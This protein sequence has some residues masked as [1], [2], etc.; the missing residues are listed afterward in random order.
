MMIASAPST[1]A[2][3]SSARWPDENVRRGGGGRCLPVAGRGARGVAGPPRRH[4]RARR[5]GSDGGGVARPMGGCRVGP[6]R[7]A[8]GAHGGDRVG[9]RPA[10]A[11]PHARVL[12]QRDLDQLAHIGRQVGGQRGGRLL[13]VLHRHRQRAVAG[14]RPL[15]RNHFVAND[16]QRVDVAGGGRVMTQGLFGCD[17][18]GGAHHHPGLGDRCGVDG[19]GDAEVGELHLPGRGDQDV[20]RLDVAVHQAGGVGDLQGATGLLEHVQRV[21]QRQPAG[22][23]DHRVQRLAV[24][25][26]HHQVGGAALAV[27]VGFAVVV[28]AAMPGW[29]SIA[30]VRA[31]ARN[32][33][34]NS[35]SDENS[36][37]E[38]L[39]RDAAA[40]PAVDGL[41]HLAHA[42]GGDQPLQ[43][44]AARQRHSNA[45]AH[46]SP[47]ARLACGGLTASRVALRPH[48]RSASGL[49]ALPQRRRDGGP[50]DRR[51]QR[52]AGGRE[53]VAAVLDQHRHRHL[54][55][56]GRARTRCTTRAAG[57]CAGR[58]RAPRCPSW[59][60]SARRGWPLSAASPARR[61]PSS[62][63]A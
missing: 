24:D 48:S 52:A 32:R 9:E 54:G 30:T 19:L 2:A 47:P 60:R 29:L 6:R 61:R 1:P 34:T 62:P 45:G 35:G 5:S 8:A 15:A 42:A 36:G 12:H 13:D 10:A 23:L 53:P 20:A 41:P 50:A 28:H 39:D 27:H 46:C 3:H 37:L 51:G 16:S 17:V 55:C 49:M 18:L 25:Q 63:L 59:M 14:E 7:A 31:S 4:G 26:L 57:C 33:S 58:C 44:V 21:P 22:A 40:Q 56:S 38:H 11:V 43:A